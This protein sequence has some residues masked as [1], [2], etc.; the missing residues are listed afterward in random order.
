[1][2]K[3]APLV[4]SGSTIRNVVTA[5]V[6]TLAMVSCT[7]DRGAA[8]TRAPV[9]TPTSA[10]SPFDYASHAQRAAFEAFLRCAA[11]HGVNYEGPFTD[12]T[13]N[14]IFF[15]L[16]AGET[17]S[18]AEQEQVSRECPEGNVGLFGT[19]IGHVHVDSFERAATEFAR[20]IH[21]E[22]YPSFP[23]PAFGDADPVATFW[24]LPF[25]WSS[26]RFSDAVVVCMDPLRSYLFAS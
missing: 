24:Q 13:G 21:S 26:E 11:A 15:R 5:F 1:V 3:I 18:H 14:G 4:R 16:A 25:D 2:A 19:P 10:Y 9:V 22:G 17:A 23:S 8:P 7:S 12:S 6:A 20:C